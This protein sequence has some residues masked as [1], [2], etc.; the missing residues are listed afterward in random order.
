MITEKR[1]I[2]ITFP[3]IEFSPS[4]TRT[5][6]PILNGEWTKRIIDAVILLKI[7]QEAKKPIPAIAKKEAANK[8]IP[9]KEIPHINARARNRIIKEEILYS[10]IT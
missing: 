7:D 1:V 5:S 3:S 9:L 6:E 2:S 10:F 4:K 8:D